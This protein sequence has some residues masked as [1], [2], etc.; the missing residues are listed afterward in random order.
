MYV[1]LVEGI[2]DKFPYSLE[3]LRRDYPNV[4]FPRNVDDTSLSIYGVYPVVQVDPPEYN[5]EYDIQMGMPVLIN[6]VWTQT[7][8]QVPVSPDKVA[9]M[10]DNIL[11]DKFEEIEEL[12]DFK[13]YQDVAYVF[14]G[15]SAT[16]YIKFRDAR[17]QSEIQ[18]AF[19][20]AT[21][22]IATGNTDPCP[23]IIV[24]DQIK[25]LSPSQMI[26]MCL[27]VQAR[28]MQLFVDAS[29]HRG[30]LTYLVAGLTGQAKLDVIRSYDITVNWSV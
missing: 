8:V 15:D 6:D 30:T 24:G 10:L 17:N 4:S 1:K 9:E 26:Q 22:K 23:F 11:A 18:V 5:I 7:W 3:Q 29:T 25:L 16:S 28:G 27:H 13:L 12:R 19:E 14:P 2:I 20:V 21:L